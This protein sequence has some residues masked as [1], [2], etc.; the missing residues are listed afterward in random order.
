MPGYITDNVE[1][2]FGDSDRED[3]SASDFKNFFNI[4]IY[5]YIYIYFL[6]SILLFSCPFFTTNRLLK[7]VILHCKFSLLVK[8]I[9]ICKLLVTFSVMNLYG[10]KLCS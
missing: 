8:F 4:Y 7:D 5:I 6:F 1:I 2:S 3:S 9:R 10:Q